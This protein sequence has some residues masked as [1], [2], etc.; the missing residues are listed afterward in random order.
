MQNL[1]DNFANSHHYF[2]HLQTINMP[3]VMN[4]DCYDFTQVIMIFN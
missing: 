1:F 2:D 4:Y 3:A